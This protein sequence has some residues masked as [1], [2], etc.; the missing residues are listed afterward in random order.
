MTIKWKKNKNLKPEIILEKIKEN[1]HLAIDGSVSFSALDYNNLI[2]SLYSMIEFPRNSIPLNNMN[3]LSR[4]IT[5]AAK[6][7]Q[8]TKDYVLKEIQDIAKDETA[9][10]ESVYKILTSISMNYEL[11]NQVFKVGKSTIKFIR[12]LPQDLLEIRIENLNSFKLN[13]EIIH[14]NYTNVIIEVKAK[15][16][17]EA[18]N[19][20]LDDLDLLRSIFCLFSNPDMI[21]FSNNTPNPINKIRLGQFHTIHNESGEIVNPK[22][23]WYEPNFI[24]NDI[25]TPNKDLDEYF[26][27]DLENILFNLEQ[28][29]YSD[30]LKNALLRYVRAFDEKNNNIALL[31]VWGALESLTAANDSN[32]DKLPKR[33]A[34]LYKEHEFHKQ[35]LENLREYRNQSVHDGIRNEYVRNYCYQVQGYFRQIIFF[36]LREYREFSSIDDANEF[37]DQSVDINQLVKKKKLIEKAIDFLEPIEIYDEV[38]TPS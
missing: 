26:N 28:C 24:L 23:Y 38:I 2:G 36:H 25:F 33:C 30:K 4:A 13:Q 14:T 8:I 5:N 17:I 18:I 29:K 22:N 11:P 27:Q 35:I 6:S 3:L 19:K 1:C 34:F 15:G 21:L 9:K 7:K 20:A 31:E 16:E 10:K 37:L 12:D 32:K